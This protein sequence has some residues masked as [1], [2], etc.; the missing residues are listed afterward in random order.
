MGYRF[1]TDNDSELIAVYCAHHLGEGMAL[2]DVLKQSLEDLD[3]TYTF[4]AATPEE[5]GFAKDKIGAK[6]FVYIEND[7]MIIL[8][9]EEVAIRSL[10]PD[11]RIPVFE[12]GP[13]KSHSWRL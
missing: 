2:T 10:I 1:R 8:A 12:P 3:G 6:P 11:E 5:M 9:S 7:D 4:V 13:L